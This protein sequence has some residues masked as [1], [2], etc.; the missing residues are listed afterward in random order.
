[1]EPQVGLTCVA[2]SLRFDTLTSTFILL[3]N[4]RF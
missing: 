1:M 3:Q 2:S 4:V